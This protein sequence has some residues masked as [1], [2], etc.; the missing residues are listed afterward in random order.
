MAAIASEGVERK[1]A[2]RPDSGTDPRLARYLGA[3]CA[4]VVVWIALYAGLQR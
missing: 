1:G 2:G 4:A 3:V